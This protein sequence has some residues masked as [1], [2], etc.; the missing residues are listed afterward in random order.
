MLNGYHGWGDA[1]K[2]FK[3]TNGP[4]TGLLANESVRNTAIDKG[5]DPS[6]VALPFP[7]PDTL[8]TYD[9]FKD[10]FRT[11]ATS[12]YELAVQ[13]GTDKSTYYAG[14]GYFKQESVVQPSNY[15]RYTARFNYD[16]YISSQLK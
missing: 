16:N 3:V 2:K 11:A 7:N 5:Q 12:N 15:E 4:Q 1:I 9:R 8:P 6:T 10:L 13:G 14:V